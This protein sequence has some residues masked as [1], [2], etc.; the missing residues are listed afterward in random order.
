MVP[1]RIELSLKL[2]CAARITG[3]RI[4]NMLIRLG[5][6]QHAAAV[7]YEKRTRLRRV[8]GM[9]PA[10]LYV[11]AQ[12]PGQAEQAVPLFDSAGTVLEQHANAIAGMRQEKPYAR[13]LDAAVVVEPGIE[14]ETVQTQAALRLVEQ[15]ERMPASIVGAFKSL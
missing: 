14:I 11:T 15:S 7:G 1:R 4:T 9:K 13:L 5:T 12:S 2:A 8:I 10:N 3:K 6:N